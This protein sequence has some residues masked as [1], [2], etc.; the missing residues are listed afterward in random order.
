MSVLSPH[1]LDQL[2]VD[3]TDA[4]LDQ[5]VAQ[6]PDYLGQ[7][8]TKHPL[9]YEAIWPGRDFSAYAKQCAGAGTPRVYKILLA[10][11]FLNCVPLARSQ[12]HP[13]VRAYV[14]GDLNRDLGEWL[15]GRDQCGCAL[16]PGGDNRLEAH[17]A[18][19]V[20]TQMQ[21]YRF[22]FAYAPAL[23]PRGSC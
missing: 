23:V 7:L 4:Y 5:W 10:L 9:L 13:H 17:T 11:V 14:E 16:V 12:L 19:F 6:V 18:G 15:A 22:A 1:T 21:R 3:P 2:L 20:T 8:A